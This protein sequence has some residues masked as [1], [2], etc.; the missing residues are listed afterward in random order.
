MWWSIVKFPHIF[1]ETYPNCR[2]QG[3]ASECP[4][5]KTYKCRLDPVWHRMLYS[6]THMA[7]VGVKELIHKILNTGHP[8][9][10]TELIQHHKPSRSTRS[11]ASHLLSVPRHYL[12]FGARAFRIAAPK[13]WNSIPLHIC[14]FQTYSSFRRHLKTHYFILSHLAP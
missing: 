14:Q 4:D 13:I 7:T 1:E 2:K 12:S 9:Y 5:V 3:W 6:C 8:P 11:S 10:L